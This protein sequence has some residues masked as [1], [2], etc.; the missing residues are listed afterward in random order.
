M[1]LFLFITGI[2]F[3]TIQTKIGLITILK[4]FQVD[5]CD[6]SPIPYVNVPTAE[7]MQPTGGMHLKFS[8]AL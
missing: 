6:K 5:I 3:G 4:N 2:R 7:M 8:K 1:T